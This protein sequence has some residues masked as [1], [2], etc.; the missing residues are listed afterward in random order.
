MA[1]KVALR[2]LQK[3]KQELAKAGKHKTKS[4]TS[5]F[6]YKPPKHHV[7]KFSFPQAR[8]NRHLFSITKV[9]KNSGKTSILS[10]AK[11][12]DFKNQKFK[13]YVGMP[14]AAHIDII[15]AD[16]SPIVFIFAESPVWLQRA[17]FVQEDILKL[18]NRLSVQPV[19]EVRFRIKRD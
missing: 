8:I 9:L 10:R 6:K 14:L 12:I 5:E 16:N 1:N 17:R 4:A 13:K 19:K 15:H 7:P 2:N 11:K 3:L 18:L